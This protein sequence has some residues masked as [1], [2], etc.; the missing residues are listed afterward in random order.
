MKKYSKEFRTEMLR[1]VDAGESPES[2]SIRFNLGYNTVREWMN[3]RKRTGTVVDTE[4]KTAERKVSKSEF[5]K[6]YEEN[7][8]AL[9]KEAAEYFHISESGVRYFQ[10]KLGIARKKAEPNYAQGD[11]E[12]QAEFEEEIREIKPQNRVYVDESGFDSYYT[13]RIGRSKRGKKICESTGSS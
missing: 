7:P 3:L 5:E 13:R 8:F 10:N 1:Y 11:P 4:R 2:V 6:Y 9:N 12:K